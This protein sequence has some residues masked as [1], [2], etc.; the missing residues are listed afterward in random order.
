MGK[1]K[2]KLRQQQAVEKQVVEKQLT[3]KQAAQLL[4]MEAAARRAAKHARK[5][6]AAEKRVAE[7]Q[8]VQLAEK[9][10]AL[11]SPKQQADDK[12]Q[13]DD[14]PFI[15]PASSAASSSRVFLM[16]YPAYQ[17]AQEFP[18][19]SATS[20]APERSPTTS[21]LSGQQLPA[22]SVVPERSPTTTFG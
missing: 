1:I 11:L 3:E 10:S 7:R 6:Q 15:M 18:A 22:P 16:S 14:A 4:R 20:S 21:L 13:A 9:H 17:S 8:A 5:Q 19:P 12:K 2:A